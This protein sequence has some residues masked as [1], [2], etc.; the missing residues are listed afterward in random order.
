MLF[1]SGLPYISGGTLPVV[2]NQPVNTT[3]VVGR[4]ATLGLTVTGSAPL[5]YQWRFNG[6]LLSGE[7]NSLLM[8]HI[9]AATNAGSYSCII[10]NS[11]GST[12][13]AAVN[14][15]VV[16]PPSITVQP[17]DVKV[18]IRPDSLAAP[19]TNATFTADGTSSSSIRYQWFFNGN[20][21][22]NATNRAYTVVNVQQTNYGQIACALTD[23]IDTVLTQPATLYPMIRPTII[24]HPASQTV[25][26]GALF[27]LSVNYT[28]FPPP[29]TNEWRRASTPL[30]NTVSQTTNDVYALLAP[31]APGTAT[32][33]VVV[34][35]VANS[36]PGVA[37]SL[38][39]IVT[40]ADS[41]GDGIPD[42]V[43]IALGL[44][45]NNGADGA[46]DLDNDLMINRDEY[47]AGTDP[48]NPAS[49]LKVA[50]TTVPGLVTLS[51]AAVANRSYSVQ[52]TD[53]L[54]GGPWTKLGDIVAK[55]T[56]RVEQMT[57]TNWTSTRFY[58]IV[59]PGQPQ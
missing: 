4:S 25:A 55:P 6:Q 49:Y 26:V 52:Y 24:T 29:F 15:S 16:F 39:N 13:S 38:A 50:Q 57:D 48:Q 51:V 20:P 42:S 44:N 28:G 27:G 54:A 1:R 47:M 58:R 19:T 40:L 10:F 46:G 53:S 43:E 12:E 7:N 2:V 36:A 31:A 30:A 35:N 14:L 22:L 11:A 45:P 34:K 56:D 17:A 3:A 23:N 37:S 5:F 33:R 59:L 18:F 32:Y 21:I 41:D 9:V 8:I